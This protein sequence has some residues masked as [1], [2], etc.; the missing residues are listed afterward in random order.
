M[1][2]PNSL[3]AADLKK[4]FAVFGHFYDIAIADQKNSCRSLLELVDRGIVPDDP[5]Q[6]AKSRPDLLIVMMN[7]G[8]SRPMDKN[9]KPKLVSGSQDIPKSREWVPTQPDNTQYQIM[10]IMLALGYK[11]GRVFNLSD[12]RE[13]KS[14]VLFKRLSA[15]SNVSNGGIHS[16]FCSERRKEL[17][18][19]LGCSNCETPVLVGWGRSTELLPLASQ[20]LLALD[21]FSIY[22]RPI[23]SKKV[24][25]FHPSPML[26][27]MKE[28]WVDTVLAQ[29]SVIN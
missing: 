26:Q 20:A 3:R 19:L 1:I 18:N 29:M 24:L 2:N 13:P 25:F 28:Q 23:D 15:I 27:R 8:S 11:H 17:K 4:K 21:G 6:L 22:G 7:P 16:I 10:R 9:Y 12:I 14:S 5:N